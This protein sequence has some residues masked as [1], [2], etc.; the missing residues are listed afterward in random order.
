MPKS[1]KAYKFRIYPNAEQRIMFAKTFGCVR[2]VYNYYLNKKICMYNVNKTRFSYVQCSNDMAL[3]KKTEKFSFLKEVDSVAL[4][5]SLR[6][7]DIAFQNFFK[8]PIVGFSKFK[9]KKLNKKSYSTINIS[10]LDGYIKLPKV[11]CVK[12]KQL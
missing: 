8:R 9:S 11:G 2:L 1:N 12:M 10:I 3:L 6:L 4:Q 5:Q 7:L